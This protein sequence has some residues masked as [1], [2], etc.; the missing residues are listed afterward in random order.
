LKLVSF[1]KNGGFCSLLLM[2]QDMFLVTCIVLHASSSASLTSS[3]SC[4][5]CFFEPE[6]ELRFAASAISCGRHLK[7]SRSH[8]LRIL[9]L[10]GWPFEP[11]RPSRLQPFFLRS[12]CKDE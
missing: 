6:H 7:A 8:R 9:L 12:G 5:T 10:D 3:A 11:Q 4:S 1:V 2:A